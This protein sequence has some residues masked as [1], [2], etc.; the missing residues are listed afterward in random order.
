MNGAGR[1]VV[2]VAVEGFGGRL[3]TRVPTILLLGCVV[4]AAVAVAALGVHAQEPGAHETAPA[5]EDGHAPA[6]PASAGHD[7]H[8]EDELG[9]ELIEVMGV[10][11]LTLLIATACAGLF[12]RKNPRVLLRWH[13]RLALVTVLS[14]ACHVALVVLFH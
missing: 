8:E 14:A 12:V 6:E 4:T 9:G 5:H 10:T 13:K 2:R 7:D 3:M 11:T 1:G